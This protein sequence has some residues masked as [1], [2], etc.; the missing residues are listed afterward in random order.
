[1]SGKDCDSTT[2]KRNEN[3]PA[4][5]RYLRLTCDIKTKIIHYT[6]CRDEHILTPFMIE[7]MDQMR[8]LKSST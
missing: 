5:I 7:P 3:Q 8:S 6:D 1:M 4:M 2:E